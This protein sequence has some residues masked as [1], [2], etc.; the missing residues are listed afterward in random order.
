[1]S[2]EVFYGL[3]KEANARHQSVPKTVDSILR[4]EL[5]LAK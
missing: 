2:K 3:Q 4:K 5:S 1:V